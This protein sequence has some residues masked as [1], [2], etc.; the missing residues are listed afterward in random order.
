MS[1]TCNSTG[2]SNFNQKYIDLWFVNFHFLSVPKFDFF[3]ILYIRQLNLIYLGKIL[4]LGWCR[5][6]CFRGFQGFIWVGQ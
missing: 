6:Y 5:L 2:E 4:N 1:I 3:I